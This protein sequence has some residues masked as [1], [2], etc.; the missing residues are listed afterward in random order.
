MAYFCLVKHRLQHWFLAILLLLSSAAQAQ[1]FQIEHEDH[2]DSVV[3][4]VRNTGP[5]WVKPTSMTI[6]WFHT[7]PDLYVWDAN[8]GPASYRNRITEINKNGNLTFKYKSTQGVGI[9]DTLYPGQRIP[10]FYS[11]NYNT[12]KT[13]TIMP[14]N[15]IL[16]YHDSLVR[17]GEESVLPK[18]ASCS[19]ERIY[20]KSYAKTSNVHYRSPV[21]FSIAQDVCQKYAITPDLFILVVFDQKTFKPTSAGVIPKCPSGRYGTAFGYPKD[22]IVYYIFTLNDGPHIDSIINGIT[23]GD[24]VALVSYP[25]FSQY[26]ISKMKSRFA[27]IGLNTDSLIVGPFGQPDVQMVFWGRKGLASNKGRLTTAGRFFKPP[28]GSVVSLG[29]DHVMITNQATDQLAAWPPCFD[30]LA[31]VHQ[32]YIPAPIKIGTKTL[33]APLAVIAYPNPAQSQISLETPTPVRW[34]FTDAMGRPVTANTSESTATTQQTLDV[35]HWSAGVYFG[36]SEGIA[37]STSPRY[38][39]QFVKIP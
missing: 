37:G 16:F 4:F 15:G 9:S 29:A 23:D 25:T 20:L 12:T 33:S 32:P 30:V 11:V 28:G 13:D 3:W 17:D 26:S 21:W 36:W 7:K 18:G 31:V 1:R 10:V 2:S 22:S 24:Y 38:R 35:A 27:P 39:T 14:A 19:Y 6:N 34:H 8:P 5:R